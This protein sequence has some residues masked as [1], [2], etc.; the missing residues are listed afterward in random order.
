MSR[1]QMGVPHNI[2][3]SKKPSPGLSRSISVSVFEAKEKGGL[4]QSTDWD[5]DG[6][7]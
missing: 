7:P 1:K 4:D 5:G 3:A 6:I 2:D